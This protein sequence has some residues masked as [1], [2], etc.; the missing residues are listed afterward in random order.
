[1]IYAMKM[2]FPPPPLLTPPMSQASSSQKLPSPNSAERHLAN[3]QR[4]IAIKPERNRHIF[5]FFK[6][7]LEL[8]NP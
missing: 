4:L 6:I 3:E 7:K 1:M 5:G 8:F 2:A